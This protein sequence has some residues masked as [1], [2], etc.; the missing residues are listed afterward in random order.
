MTLEEKIQAIREK[1]IAAN[2]DEWKSTAICRACGSEIY[3]SKGTGAIVFPWQCRK[4][5]NYQEA[6][7]RPIRLADLLL[8]I[9]GSG[10]IADAS[11]QYRGLI[12]IFPH[13]EAISKGFVFPEPTY[14]RWNALQ[15]DLSKQSPETVEFIHSLL[16]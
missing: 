12:N 3:A 5:G 15:D 13:P 9:A 7:D 10:L 16:T 14:F 6:K 8:A 11:V 2:P 4:C 1:C